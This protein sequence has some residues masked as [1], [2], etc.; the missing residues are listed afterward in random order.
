MR[1][2]YSNAGGFTTIGLEG[3]WS[4]WLKVEHLTMLGFKSIKAI[5]VRHKFK[6]IGKC[7]KIHL[8]WMPQRDVKPP[9]WDV[10]K[11]L[12]GVSFCMAHPLYRAEK[13]GEEKLMELC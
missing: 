12:D 7:S 8:M 9:D 11:V 1:E 5:A 4:P 3:H 6:H 13:Y 2:D 10:N